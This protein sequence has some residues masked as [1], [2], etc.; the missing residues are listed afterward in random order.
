VEKRDIIFGLKEILCVGRLVEKEEGGK[1]F[2]VWENDGSLPKTYS[3]VIEK[4]NAS[5][6]RDINGTKFVAKEQGDLI[7]VS[8]YYK[9]W[10][11]H[12]DHAP[13]LWGNMI[14]NPDEVSPAEFERELHEKMIK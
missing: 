14:F 2:T 5:P 3:D 12:P 9:D 10:P 1:R 11:G 7:V 13:E 4:L 8:V 6:E